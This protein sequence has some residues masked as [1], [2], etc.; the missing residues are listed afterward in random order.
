[1]LEDFNAKNKNVTDSVLL[2][3]NVFTV[4]FLSYEQLSFL[5]FFLS[6]KLVLISR[7]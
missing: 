5:S 1:M 6:V 7:K 4:I 3:Q 2:V